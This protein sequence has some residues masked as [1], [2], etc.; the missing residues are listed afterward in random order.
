MLTRCLDA[1][2][3]QLADLDPG[4]VLHGGVVK[5]DLEPVPDGDGRARQSHD[6]LHSP[7]CY[8]DP[9]DEAQYLSGG[10]M[11]ERDGSG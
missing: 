10:V 9:D 1:A 2:G 5:V 3:G 8:L 4:A 6:V 7:P 11:S